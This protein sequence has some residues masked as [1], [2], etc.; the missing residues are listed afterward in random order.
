MRA[1]TRGRI[2]GVKLGV[3]PNSSSIGSDLS[4]LLVGSTALFFLVNVL[5]LGIRLWLGRHRR[6]A[7]D[8]RE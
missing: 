8:A 4:V 5:D 1:D 3:N 7:A 6:H 2:L